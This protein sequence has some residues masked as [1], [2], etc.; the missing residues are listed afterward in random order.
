MVKTML[1]YIDESDAALHHIIAASD[2]LFQGFVTHFI[3]QKIH[4]IYLIGSGTSYNA[5]MAMRSG[6]EALMHIPVI[7]VYPEWL[8]DAYTLVG[9]GDMVVG[10][11]HGGHSRSTIEALDYAKTKGAYTVAV[12]GFM[13]API[14]MHGD[15]AVYMASGEETVGAKT[16]GFFGSMVTVLLMFAYLSKAKGYIDGSTMDHLVARIQ[17][18]SGHISVNKTHT[19]NWLRSSLD[20]LTPYRRIIVV[21]YDGNI[22][23]LLEGSLKLIE[24]CRYSVA[25]YDQEE[26]MHGIYHSIDSNTLMIYLASTGRGYDRCIQLCNYIHQKHDNPS[27]VITSSSSIDVSGMVLTIESDE[28]PWFKSMEY[29]VALQVLAHELSKGIGIDANT[30]SD[31]LFH[32]TMGSYV[33]KD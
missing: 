16:K 27:I 19:L 15:I 10:L 23:A 12:T 25:W 13:D 2:H 5:L 14:V 24:G 20:L 30:S 21:G 11:S 6:V 17:K 4:M 8:I 26:F 31:P 22:G 29:V 9:P 33:G 18:A 3:N 28:D 1:D 32:A 7:T